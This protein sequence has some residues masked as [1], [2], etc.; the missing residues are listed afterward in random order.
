V[1]TPALALGEQTTADALGIHAGSLTYGAFLSIPP[2]LLIVGSVLGFVLAGDA[3]AQARVVD[4]IANV[5]PGL[6]PFVRDFL[7][8]AIDGRAS[9]GLLGLVALTWTASGFAARASFALG[10]IFRTARPGL[11]AGRIAAIWRGL[12]VVVGLMA[13]IAAMGIAGGMGL[14]NTSDAA[15]RAVTELLVLAASFV[16]FLFA[17]RVLTPGDGP[18]LRGHV[19]GALL[20]TVGFTIARG[21]GETYVANVVARTTALYGA[22]GAIFGL[23]AFL[24]AT[25]WIFLLGAELSRFSA[26]RDAASER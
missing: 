2:A 16:V 5:I 13:S 4:Q 10:E 1:L 25:M 9:V 24:Y 26:E 21:I 3:E 15:W 12:P 19:K 17:Y 23:L 7:Q 14:G 11:I 6:E 18:T 22:I 20:F 8:S